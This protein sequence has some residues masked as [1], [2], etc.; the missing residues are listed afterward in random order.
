MHPYVRMLINAILKLRM[1]SIIN[2]EFIDNNSLGKT[3]KLNGKFLLCT[4]LFGRVYELND[5]VYAN[6]KLLF[7]MY[8]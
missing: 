7:Y 1:I 3:G 2:N 6:C 8:S 5:S 4:F